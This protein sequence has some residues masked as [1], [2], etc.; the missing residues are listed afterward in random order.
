[1]TEIILLLELSNNDLF[2]VALCS[3]WNLN[4]QKRNG[5]YKEE[6]KENFR[7]EKYNN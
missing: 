2:S 7:T 6:L 5:R 4:F 1:M 3:W